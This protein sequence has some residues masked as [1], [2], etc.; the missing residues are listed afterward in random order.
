MYSITDSDYDNTMR[1]LARA[2]VKLRNPENQTPEVNKATHMV[3]EATRL[4]G[5]A[6]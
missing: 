1:L 3:R 2:I 5:K 4:L 6:A